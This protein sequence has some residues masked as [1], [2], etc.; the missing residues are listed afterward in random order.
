[1]WYSTNNSDWGLAAGLTNWTTN[2]TLY[3]QIGNVSYVKS[4]NE[5]GYTTTISYIHTNYVD[6][7]A[8]LVSITNPAVGAEL[9]NIA[10]FI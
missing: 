10:S 8:P 3:D 1:M 5:Y 9:S 2:V 7:T 6:T 4:S